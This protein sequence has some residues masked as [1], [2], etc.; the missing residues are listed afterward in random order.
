MMKALGLPDTTGDSPTEDKHQSHRES[1]HQ[2]S[3]QA[4]MFEAPIVKDTDDPNQDE[5]PQ[6]LRIDERAKNKPAKA[7]KSEQDEDLPF[8]NQSRGDGPFRGIN[9][10]A[11]HIKII[12]EDQ[13]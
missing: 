6:G 7:G 3:Q 9:A 5:H 10:V 13:G 12:V 4:E 8:G 1:D 11:L 2:V